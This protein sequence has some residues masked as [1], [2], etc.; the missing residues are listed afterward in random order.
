MHS[1]FLADLSQQ[2]PVPTCLH[3]TRAISFALI[4]MGE[5]GPFVNGDFIEHSVCTPDT[6]EVGR[7]TMED[8]ILRVDIQ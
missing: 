7:R 4:A 6:L 3:L 8:A 2:C 1:L 5:L